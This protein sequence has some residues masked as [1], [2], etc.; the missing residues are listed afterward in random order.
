MKKKILCLALCVVMVFASLVGCEEDSREEIMNNMGKEASDKKEA[1]TITMQL[2]SEKPV[3]K[4]QEA[5]V[6]EAKGILIDTLKLIDLKNITDWNEV[7]NQIRKPLR[8]FFYKKTKRSP[9]ILPI[10]FRV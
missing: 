4:E 10:I 6:E 7:R 9:M 5:L 1:I 8:N 2:L 3:S